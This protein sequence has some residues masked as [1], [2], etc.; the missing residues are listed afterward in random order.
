LAAT[1]KDL[2]CRE[3][4]PG[5]SFSGGEPFG[6]IFFETRAMRAMRNDPI[7]SGY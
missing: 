4:A 1:N 5:L 6:C 3:R 2:A 7:S